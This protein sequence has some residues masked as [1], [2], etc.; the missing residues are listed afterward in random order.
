MIYKNIRLIFIVIVA[1]NILITLLLLFHETILS[2]LDQI[3]MPINDE[4]CKSMPDSLIGKMRHQQNDN[5]NNVN[6]NSF[7]RIESDLKYLALKNGGRWYPSPSI[8][9]AKQN[10]HQEEPMQKVAIIVPYRDRQINLELFLRY[11]HP[12][13]TNQKIYYGIYLIEPLKNLTFNRAM[14]MNIGFIE[15]QKE[16]AYDCYIFHD[17]D[18]LPENSQNLYQCQKEMPKQMAIAI[19]TY[20]YS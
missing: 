19:S 20:S 13:L 10:N 15:S 16:D 6:T 8:E 5:N 2:S 14:L 1:L 9:Q 12:F 18:M 3:I 11:M 4:L 17:V 7:D